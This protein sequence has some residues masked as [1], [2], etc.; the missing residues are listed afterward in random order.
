MF[1][2]THP[3]T[4]CE[5]TLA[6]ASHSKYDGA[7]NVLPTPLARFDDVATHQLVYVVVVTVVQAVDIFQPAVPAR[8]LAITDPTLGEECHA[9]ATVVQTEEP[10]PRSIRPLR[11][12]R[13]AATTRR[14]LAASSVSS[15]AIC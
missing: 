1:L 11:S 3:L 8:P 5:A 10:A 7:G 14:G 12:F 9:D 13:G 15:S 4:I 6:N 2:L